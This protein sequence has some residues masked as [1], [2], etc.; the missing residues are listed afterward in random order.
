[1]R[2]SIDRESF[3]AELVAWLEWRL[4]PSGVPITAGTVLFEDRL[5]DSIRILELIAWIERATGRQIPDSR[6]VMSNF[7]TPERI[8]DVFLGEAG[9]VAD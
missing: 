3:I 4:A 7:R 6:I 2:T 9:D 8:A 5:I 1:M